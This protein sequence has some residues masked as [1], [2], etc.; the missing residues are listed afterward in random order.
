MLSSF[1]DEK[2]FRTKVIHSS[3]PLLYWI[4]TTFGKKLF[5]TPKQTQKQNQKK[6]SCSQKLFTAPLS[7]HIRFIILLAKSYSQSYSQST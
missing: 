3:V 6:S 1:F 7:H 4:Y 5:T 2:P